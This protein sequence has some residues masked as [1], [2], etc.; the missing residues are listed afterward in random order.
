M[1][2]GTAGSGKL[3]GIG[4]GKEIKNFKKQGKMEEGTQRESEIKM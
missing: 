4:D 3:N 1:G 2:R